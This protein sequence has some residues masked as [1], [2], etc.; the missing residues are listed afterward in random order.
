MATRFTCQ[1]EALP[2]RPPAAVSPFR[3]IVFATDFSLTGDNAL[4]AAAA[5]TRLFDADLHLMHALPEMTQHTMVSSSYSDFHT[6]VLPANDL[7]IQDQH[8]SEA[9]AALE[10]LRADPALAGL[11]VTAEVVELPLSA[12]IAAGVKRL[13]ADLVVIGTHARHGIDRVWAGSIAEAVLRHSQCPVLTIGP[14]ALVPARIGSVLL[15]SRL[16]PGAQSPARYAAA[17]ARERQADLA[18]VHVVHGK[19]PP[20]QMSE[21]AAIEAR[22]AKLLPDDGVPWRHLQFRINFGNPAREILRAAEEL[23]PD[24]LVVGVGE[25][26]ASARWPALTTHLPWTVLPHILAVITC[27]MLAVRSHA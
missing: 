1:P 9:C 23:N 18:L 10:L 25:S 7:G 3:R 21:Y 15:A 2:R 24:L 22:L 8:R 5:Y 26:L 16:G 20:G 12:G 19:A 27:P 11:R 6:T 14:A 4:R 17:I 13:N